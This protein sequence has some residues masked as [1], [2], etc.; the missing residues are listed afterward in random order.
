MASTF[1]DFLERYHKDS[2]EFLN[3]IIRVT[4]DE[5]WILF[6]DIETKEQSKQWMRTHSPNK[7]K[8]FKQMSAC[9]KADDNCFFWTGKEG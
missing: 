5:I 3:H 6:V 4:D 2:D 7:P 8:M 9:Q 1:V